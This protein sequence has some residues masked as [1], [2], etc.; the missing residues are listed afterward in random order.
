MSK[1]TPFSVSHQV[2]AKLA[3]AL[4]ANEN[5]WPVQIVENGKRQFPAGLK[6]WVFVIP[7]PF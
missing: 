7:F 5:A 4:P 6:S 1:I 2:R 3:G